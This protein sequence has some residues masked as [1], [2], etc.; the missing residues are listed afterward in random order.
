M[1]Y[2]NFVTINNMRPE[3][4]Q[5]VILIIYLAQHILNTIWW[6]H[7]DCYETI[8]NKTDVN[9]RDGTQ[10]LQY[11]NNH[12]TSSLLMLLSKLASLFSFVA[13]YIHKERKLV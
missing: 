4:Y 5:Y 6:R 13:V 12:E 1:S 7:A 8:K 10:L 11:Y 2:V 9:S 3:Q